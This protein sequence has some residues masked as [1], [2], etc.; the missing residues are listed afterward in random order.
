MGLMLLSSG[1]GQA[2]GGARAFHVIVAVWGV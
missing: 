1:R 2:T